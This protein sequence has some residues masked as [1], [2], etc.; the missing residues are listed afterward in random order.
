MEHHSLHH[1]DPSGRLVISILLNGLITLVEIA[2]GIFSNSL[3]LISD[4]IHNLSDTLALILAWLANKFSGRKPNARRTFGYR[5]FEILSAFLN[6]SILTAISIYL[7]YEAILRFLQPEPVRSGL[8]F[9][10]AVIGLG[11]NLI[12]MLF[13]HRDSHKNLNIKAAYLHLLGDTLSSVAV[14]GGAILIY[15]TKVLWIDPLLTFIISIVIIIQAY[16]ILRE[17]IDILMQSTPE[18]LDLDEIR[19]L[20]EKH[21]MIKNIHHV[22]CWRLQDHDILFE[23]HIETS[24]DLLLSESAKLLNEVEGIL[25]KKFHITHTTLQVEFDVC[26]DKA[27]IKQNPG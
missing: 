1:E 3:A 27:M 23:A 5:R 11:A 7:I 26:G 2:G 25:K 19:I 20:L 14:V 13:L 17:S 21:P 12:S 6:A 18:S 22:H 9:I 10:I 15:Y 4:A 24:E 8:M 16:K